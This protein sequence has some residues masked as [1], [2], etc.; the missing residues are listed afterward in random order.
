MGHED[1]VV[2]EIPGGDVQEGTVFT[3]PLEIASSAGESRLQ[4]LRSRVY[5]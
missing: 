4:V 5:F 2:Y 1:S 3:K